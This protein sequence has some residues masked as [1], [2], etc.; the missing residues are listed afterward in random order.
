MKKY[1]APLLFLL[2]F[3]ISWLAWAQKET[4][5]QIKVEGLEDPLKGKIVNALAKRSQSI[6]LPL[7]ADKVQRFYKKA[8]DNIRRSLQPYGYF[9]PQIRSR[10]H[11][12]SNDWTLVFHVT[13]GP[14]VK[15][16]HID[17]TI[18]GAG[19]KDP[20]FEHLAKDIPIKVGQILNIDDYEQTKNTLFNLS[21]NRGYFDAKMV[22][23]QIMINIETQQASIVLHF[24]TGERY[25][26]G[27]TL[28]PP[29]D[30]NSNF[31]ERF[32]RYKPGEYYSGTQVQQTQQVMAGSGFFSQTVVTPEPADAKNLTVPIKIELTPVKPR[33]YTLGLGYGTDTG[34]RGTL[35]F[36]WIPINAYGHHINLLARGSYINSGGQARQ[37]DT[38]NASYIIPGQDPATDSYA[39]T[40]GYGNIVQD[41]GSAKSFKVGASYNTILTPDWQQALAI[42]YLQERYQLT[43]APNTDADVLYPSGHWQYIRN[44]NI[45]KEKIISQGIS[46]S[47]DIAGASQ[48]ILSKTNFIQGKA[49]FK[50]LT[51]L[52]VTHTRFLFRTQVGRTQIDN[53]MELP[54]TLQLVAGG[55]ASIRGFKYNSLGP[56]RNLIILSGEIQQKVYHD[57]YLSTFLDTGSVTDSSPLDNAGNGTYKA[58]AGAGV[59]VLTPI[60]AVEL[61]LARPILNGGK[62]WQLEFSVGA[63]L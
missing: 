9:Q 38:I 42:T 14:A 6:P 20:A 51:T 46:A 26:F 60:G 44:R 35:G 11:S 58:G 40:T 19:A 63:E 24:D 5:L 53:L 34:P 3:G 28:F 55:P 17:L 8:P 54:L 29:S 52:D 49:G 56:G 2:L 18:N 13:P 37:N 33:R 12:A 30:L 21:A 23:N 25:Q 32:L 16:T 50:A 61:A 43:N 1:I 4:T 41:T 31:L 22:T 27:E 45:L 10:I 59:V 47:F 36:N 7:T 62:T 48:A 57:W 15:I 39:F